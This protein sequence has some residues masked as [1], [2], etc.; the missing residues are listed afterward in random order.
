M[1][2]YPFRTFETYGGPFA[3]DGIIRTTANVE[4]NI[5]RKIDFN[6]DLRRVQC[7]R[8]SILTFVG[9]DIPSVPVVQGFS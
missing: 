6:V 4:G 5:S 7:R 8:L 2:E 3:I 9:Q 1:T